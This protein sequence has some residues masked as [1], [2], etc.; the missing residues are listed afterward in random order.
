MDALKEY[1]VKIIT[2]L[3]IEEVN[4]KG[5]SVMDRLTGERRFIEAEAMVLA[6]GTQSVQGLA[7][8]LEQK[9]IEHVTIGDCRE[10]RNV[11]DSVY[12]G[13]L[14]SRQI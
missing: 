2:E 4:D 5:V 12:E 7:E 9:P 13:S 3:E 8:A 10:P 11:M 14:I 1:Q 6:M